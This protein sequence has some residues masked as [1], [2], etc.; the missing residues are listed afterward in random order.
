LK[1]LK[2]VGVLPTIAAARDDA[3][4]S[5]EKKRKEKGLEGK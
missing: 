2:S 5:K 4:S 3:A 1:K